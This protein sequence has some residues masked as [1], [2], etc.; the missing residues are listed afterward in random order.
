MAHANWRPSLLENEFAGNEKACAVPNC[1]LLLQCF[2]LGKILHCGFSFRNSDDPL[3]LNNIALESYLDTFKHAIEGIFRTTLDG[4][5]IEVNPA[6]ARIYGYDSPEELTSSLQDLNTQLY[7]EPDRRAEFV[8]RMRADGSVSDFESEIRTRDGRIIWISEFARI[9]SDEN[10]E[11]RYFEGS[12]IDISAHKKAELALKKNQ[13]EF[14]LLVETTNVVPWEADIKTGRFFYVGPQAVPFLGFPLEEWMQ[15]GFWVN[16]LHPE[17]REWVMITRAEAMEKGKSFECEYR[18]L[19]ADGRTVW[20]RDMLSV[21]PSSEGGLIAGGFMLDVTYRRY[22]EESLRESRYFIEQIASASPVILYLYDVVGRRCLY[23]NGLVDKILG[24]STWN[25]VEMSPLFTVALAHPDETEAHAAFFENLVTAQEGQVVEREFRLRGANGNW[26]WL[27]SRETVFK[28]GPTGKP[29]QIVAVATDITAHRT[30]LD[31][32]A[33]NEAFFRS[34]A[35]TTGMIPFEV[36]LQTAQFTYVGPQAESLFGYPLSHWIAPDFWQSIIHPADREPATKLGLDPPEGEEADVH[37]E[38]RLRK[39]SGDYV[40]VR[41]VVRYGPREVQGGRARGFLFDIS[42]AKVI[43]EE[44]ERS[45]RQLRELGLRNQ[46]A[47]EEERISVAREIHDELGQALTLFRIDLAWL[48][49]RMVKVLSERGAEPVVRKIAQ[50]K[51]MLDGTLQTVRRITTNLRPPVL[52]EL[53]LRAAIE[54]QAEGFSRRV[55]I[56][57]EVDAE[58]FECPCKDT[59]TAL[60]RIFQEILTNVARHAQASRVRVKFKK[61]DA[62]FVLVVSDNGRGFAEVTSSKPKSFGILGMGERAEAL[63]GRVDISS[64]LAQGTTV[65]VKLPVRDEGGK[66]SENLS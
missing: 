45:R 56:R 41:Q 15:D 26:V 12:V 47:R 59:S 66:N 13:D 30:V 5:W 43:E 11:P 64:G 14:R 44:R 42:A 6:L 19:R 27:H 38:F 51:R 46:S 39:T 50:M 53:G 58:S 4:R 28:V 29:H 31:K 17:D 48:E 16:R 2:T 54:W 52:D 33:S 23:L 35:E 65:T 49:N 22:T 37:A 8:R 9:V 25:L 55:G 60:F 3:N 20:V 10:A 7:V 18:M 32:L 36:D 24:Y 62:Y 1:D 21:I 57:C 40:W 63:G 34:L 61:E